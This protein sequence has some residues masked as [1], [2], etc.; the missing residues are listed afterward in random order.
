VHD[1]IIRGG[2]LVD[3]TGGDARHADVAIDQGRI[4]EVG[5]VDAA[6][7]REIDADGLLVTPGWVDIHTHYDGQATWDPELAPSSWHGVTT[8]VMGNCGV[9]FAPARPDR[10]D[11]LIGLMEGVEDIPG[12]AL[13]EGIEWEWE[14]FPEYLDA[15]E[16]RHWTVDVGTQVPHGAVRAY[17]MGDRGARNEVATT[18]DIAA[19]RAI[20]LEALEAGAM[21]FTTSRTL[22]HRAIDGEPVPGT[23]AGE[24]ELFGI[25]LALADAGH[26]IFELAPIGSAGELLGDVRGEVDWMRR[27]SAAIDRPVTYVLLQVDE[28]PELWRELLAASSDAVAEGSRLHPQ[29]AGRPTGLLT[30]HHATLC[31]FSEIPAYKELRGRGLSPEKLAV[32]LGDAEVRESIL[33]WRPPTPGVAEAMD[34][35]YKRTYVLGDPPDYEPG[36][37][38]SL[39]AIA[40]SLG[41]SPLEVAYDMMLEHDGQGLLYLPILNYALGDLDHVREMLLHERGLLSLSDGGAHTGTICDASMP[42]FMLTHW[43][44]DRSRGETLPLEYVVKKQTHDTA[45]LYGMNDRGT[46]EP[47]MLGDLNLIDYD[48]LRLGSPYVTADLPAGGRRLLQKA[49]GYAC[50]IKKG[51]VTFENGVPTGEQP[52]RLLRGGR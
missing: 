31:L 30:G 32:A 1:L 47:G 24:D 21:G 50:T 19:M 29:V 7:Q 27:L 33:S 38:R 23:Y 10:H 12:T 13:A 42:T 14:T 15:L 44:R 48:A 22:G 2:T 51:T 6:S 8:L 41:V 39:A 36:P 46:V 3:G 18:E 28:E 4:T 11:W 34:K 16:R 37:E 26:G 45:R 40:E 43:T 5:Q 35:A 49:T 25:G 52:G 9:G 20:V 17:V